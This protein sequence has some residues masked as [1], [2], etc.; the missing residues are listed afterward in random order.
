[1]LLA[2]ATEAAADVRRAGAGRVGA[3]RRSR[4]WSAT[5]WRRTRTTGRSRPASW[6]SGSTRRLD[7]AQA[8]GRRAGRPRAA[9]TSR[10]TRLPVRPRSTPARGPTPAADP[11]RRRPVRSARPRAGGAAVPHGGV[12][13]GGDRDHEAARLRPRRRRR[14]GRERPG[15]DPGAA[16]RAED[17]AGGAALV[18]RAGRRASGPIDVELHLHHADPTQENQLTVHVLFRPSHPCLLADDVWR[19]G[20]PLFVELRVPDG[21]P[22]GV[23][24]RTFTSRRHST[25]RLRR[26][27]SCVRSPGCRDRQ[28]CIISG[29]AAEDAPVDGKPRYLAGY[30]VIRIDDGPLDHP[31]SVREFTIDGV[32]LPAPGPSNVSI[33]EV[34]TTAEE[35]R[36]E[37]IRLNAPTPGKGASTSGKRPTS[38]W[39]AVHTGRRS[40]LR[41]RAKGRPNPRCTRPRRMKLTDGSCSPTAAAGELVVRP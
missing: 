10:P 12:D 3:A 21:Q 18:A 13:A 29:S 32:A 30:A 40:G 41:R 5:A 1:M 24:R 16:G 2:H 33:K 11:R 28:V 22:V 26:N 36:Q 39:T 37:V 38:S 31:S 19:R 27:L 14:G 20:A 17:A 6:P 4:S 35:A 34:V 25:R 23:R 7:R 8:E 15:A 9:T